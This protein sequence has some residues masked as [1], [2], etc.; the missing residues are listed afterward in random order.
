MPLYSAGRRR[1]IIALALTSAL[2]LTLDLRGNRLFELGLGAVTLALTAASSKTD[3][4]LIERVLGEH[5]RKSFLAGWLQARGV[6]W[7]ADLIPDL[8]TGES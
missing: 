7:A 1:V 2:L 3:Q 4:A 8:S 5:G 6:P